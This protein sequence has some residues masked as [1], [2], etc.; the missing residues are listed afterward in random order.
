MLLY[1]GTTLEITHPRILRSE[2]GRDFGFAFY[3][4]DIREQAERWA[5]RRRKLRERQDG[6]PCQAIVNVYEYNPADDL[7][8]KT[9][10]GANLEWLDFVVECRSNP[11]YVHGYDIVSGKIANDRVGETISYVVEGIMRREDALRRLRFEQINNQLAFCTPRALQTLTFLRSYQLPA[12][13]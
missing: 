6:L 7:R 10:D 13:P 8:V 3:T 2:V 12:Q 9:F 5:E 1:H 11:A 4:T